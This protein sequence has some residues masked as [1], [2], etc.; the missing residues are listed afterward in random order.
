MTTF[1]SRRQKYVI[2]I[3][4]IYAFC[5]VIQHASNNG[6]SLLPL[7]DTYSFSNYG[8]YYVMSLWRVRDSV[9]LGPALDWIF[10]LYKNGPCTS[11]TNS[12]STI[13][14]RAILRRCADSR[15]LSLVAYLPNVRWLR[16]STYFGWVFER[17]NLLTF[18]VS[19]LPIYSV[20]LI[21]FM[22]QRMCLRL[23]S[24]L[25]IFKR[26][27][28][29]ITWMTLLIRVVCPFVNQAVFKTRK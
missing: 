12:V 7:L 16:F 5:L 20:K 15:L 11:K 26:Y 1:A 2:N 18:D 29:W 8:W 4:N 21:P 23:L 3:S 14:I 19:L 9:M 13:Q 25:W 27:G 17:E 10:Y 22:H 6:G 24:G 28:G